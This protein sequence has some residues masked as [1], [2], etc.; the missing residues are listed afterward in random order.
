VGSPEDDPRA[1]FGRVLLG[2]GRERATEPIGRRVGLAALAVVALAG[3]L[4]L[5]NVPSRGGVADAAV[6]ISP[7]TVADVD[8]ASLPVVSIDRAVAG[9]SA[10][11]ATPAGAQDLAASLAWNLEVEA[12][13]VRTGDAS[14]LPA[15]DDGAR[16]HQLQAIIMAAS[17]SGP[18]V[19]T[20][21]TFASLHLEVVFP[22][23]LQRG[24]NAGLISTG[25][26]DDVSYSTAGQETARAKRPF[27]VTFSL[28]QTTAGRWLVTDTPLAPG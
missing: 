15:V 10:R 9:L 16:L 24:A 2:R 8:P 18:R 28:R 20:A 11:L 22:G 7:D 21:Y 12:E 5:A 3:A 14:L 23:G 6:D 19:V 17:T 25:T 1:F 26:I 4:V 27:A 13:A